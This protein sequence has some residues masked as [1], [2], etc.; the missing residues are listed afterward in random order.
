M[1]SSKVKIGISIALAAMLVFSSFGYVPIIANDSPASAAS[2]EIVAKDAGTWFETAFATWKGSTDADY[3]VYVRGENILDWRDDSVIEGFLTD[4]TLVNDEENEQLVRVVDEARGT[5]RVDIPGLPKGE[6]EIQ[7]RDREGKVLETISNLET[8]SF[9]RNGAA[10]VPSNENEFEGN[11]E[12]AL[13]GAVGGYLPDGR[14]NPEA[15]IIYVTEENK[16]TTFWGNAVFQT[17]RGATPNERTPLIVRFVGTVTGGDRLV[18]AGNGNITFEGIGPDALL[19]GW[20]IRTGGAHNI[21]IRNLNFDYWPNDA[22]ELNGQNTTTR[23][24]NYWVHNNSFGYGQNLHLA[25]AADPDQA[26]GD[27]AVDVTSHARNYTIAYNHFNGSSKVMLIGGGTGSISAHYGTIDHNWFEG[28]EERTPR[29]RNGRVHVFN[30]LFE[31]VQGHPYHNTLLERNT[32]Y[33]IGAA[34]NANVWA[35]GNIFDNVNFP[36]LRSRQGHARGFQSNNFGS[37]LPSGTPNAGFNHF[38]GDAPGFIV[39]Y[40]AVAQGDF[41]ETVEG[42]RTLTDVMPGITQEDLDALREAA[43]NLQPN[44][45]D[46][47]SAK[48]FNVKEDV[49]IVVAH[50]ST[51]T[52]PNMSTSPAAQLDWKFRPSEEGVWPTGTAEQS[53]A[54]RTEIETY[55][56]AQ[57]AAKVQDAPKTPVISS[58]VINDEVRSAVGAF[59]EAP[60]KIVV[61][62][63]TFTVKWVNADVLTENY[64]IQWDQGSNEW[65]TLATVKANARPTS[66]IT[67]DID[68]FANLRAILAEAEEGGA[69]SFRVR[70]LNS[71]GASEWSDVYLVGE[72]SVVDAAPSA[73]VNKLNGNQN[74]LTVTVTETYQN[75]TTHE[76][77]DTFTI[78]NNAEGTYTVGDYKVFVNT[79]GNTQIREISIVNE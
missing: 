28:S 14:V 10:F 55:S 19:Y 22:I 11:H 62:E 58:V 38:F 25:N 76:I 3:E 30:N 1:F 70:A 13:D 52:N 59:I 36:F 26:K 56:G 39:S 50:D 23:G 64:E 54:L 42:F 53:Q 24:S 73:V 29:V 66:F 35:E 2:N 78:K 41:P 74:E 21:V 31:D 77:S 49:G 9:P 17:D 67:Q 6:Y 71:A 48:N 68:Q 37:D 34:H 7:I 69:Y 72:L 44:V 60:G 61:H 18:G 32:G 47:N 12:F 40:E 43:L 45:F 16:E 65:T 15:Q 46:E 33:G 5:W 8:R 75:R 51:T 79:K 63:N 27:G 20:G 57:N 4:W